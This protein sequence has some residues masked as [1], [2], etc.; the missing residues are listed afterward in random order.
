MKIWIPFKLNK[1]TLSVIGKK[2]RIT[3][4]YFKISSRATV[5]G[6]YYSNGVVID[7]KV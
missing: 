1:F 4:I 7:T 5:L 6:F 2:D 3:L